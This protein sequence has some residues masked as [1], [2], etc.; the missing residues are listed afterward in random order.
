MKSL[1]EYL[2]G[3]DMGTPI[4]NAN[5]MVMG[6]KRDIIEIQFNYNDEQ[7]SQNIKYSDIKHDGDDDVWYAEFVT[8]TGEKYIVQADYTHTGNIGYSTNNMIVK[9]NNKKITPDVRIIPYSTFVYGTV[10]RHTIQI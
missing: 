8:K 10:S 7:I 6:D 1:K 9:I 5:T 3:M 2:V 4:C